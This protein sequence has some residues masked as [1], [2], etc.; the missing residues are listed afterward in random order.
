MILAN[1]E[2]CPVTS[3]NCVIQMCGRAAPSVREI[4]KIL[5]ENVKRGENVKEKFASV[6]K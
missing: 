4:H 6:K 2:V 3:L 1:T 5:C